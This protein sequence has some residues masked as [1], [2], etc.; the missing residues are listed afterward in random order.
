MTVVTPF[1]TFPNIDWWAQMLNVGT[2]IFDAGEHFEKMTFRNRYQIS[3]ANNS[4]LLSVP[5]VHGR[6]Q[7]IPMK[8]VR[9]HNGERWQVQHWRTLVSVYKRS[10]YFDHYEEQLKPLFETP[11][12]HLIDFNRAGI[13]WVS[14]QLSLEFEMQETMDF[15]KEYPA[16]VTDLRPLKFYREQD[17]NLQFPKYYQVFEDRIGFLPN[18]S[19]LDLLF[20]EGP[21]AVNW[22]KG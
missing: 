13:E 15:V 7:H 3:G 12:T 22:L 6:N 1:F 9:I 18:L 20:S 17:S 16:D 4:I 14:R 11:Y 5:L 10:P 21:R 19:I 8:D 2:V